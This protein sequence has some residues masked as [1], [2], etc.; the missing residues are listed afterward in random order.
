MVTI[1]LTVSVVIVT[2]AVFLFRCL[3]VSA[4]AV[5]AGVCV[6]VC[7]C[8][9]INVSIYM[10]LYIHICKCMRIYTHV[11]T[12]VY[13]S[14]YVGLFVTSIALLDAMQVS[15]L[16]NLF[17]FSR[18]C[19]CLHPRLFECPADFGFFFPRVQ[20][21]PWAPMRTSGLQISLQKAWFLWIGWTGPCC[22]CAGFWLN[23]THA[24]PAFLGIGAL[25][26]ALAPL[27]S[28]DTN[29][30]SQ[31]DVSWTFAPFCPIESANIKSP[32]AVALCVSTSCVCV[33]LQVCCHVS[34]R[35]D[36]CVSKPLDASAEHKMRK[37]Q[38][39]RVCII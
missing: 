23:S 5:C 24:V 37:K 13:V 30:L 19:A 38:G 8:V 4:A 22:A 21:L 31:C 36:F 14:T 35:G 34:L 27:L 2:M 33:Y 15:F 10:Y 7:V 12:Y 3:S 26:F 6:C 28:R 32:D 18:A 17:F 11:H 29:T 20:L 1:I 25:R 39:M 16:A 9:Y